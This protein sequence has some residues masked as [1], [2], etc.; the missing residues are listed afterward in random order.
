MV[1]WQW[2]NRGFFSEFNLFMFAN[3]YYKQIKDIDLYADFSKSNLGNVSLDYFFEDSTPQLILNGFSNIGPYNNGSKLKSYF[4]TK[5]FKSLIGKESVTHHE[6]FSTVWSKDFNDFILKEG[7]FDDLS[8]FFQNKWCFSSVT[9]SFIENEI[10]TLRLPQEYDAF[11]IRRGDKLKVEAKL[12]HISEYVNCLG[13]QSCKCVFI[14]T[15]DYDVINEVRDFLPKEIDVKHLC[16][17][18]KSG[19]DQKKFNSMSKE[20]I[21]KEIL[22]LLTEVEIM[23]KAK[24]FVGSYSSNIGVALYLL[25]SGNRCHSV[26]IDFTLHYNP[27]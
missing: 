15:D 2:T 11:H 12:K 14:S 23:R 7:Y 4:M 5:A 1:Y 26:D 17:E 21:Q 6:A 16:S 25:R 3:F 27:Y 8:L 19:H 18:F 9:S 13:K 22:N 10:S 20:S 24:N